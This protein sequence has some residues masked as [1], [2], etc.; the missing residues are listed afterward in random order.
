MPLRRY[1]AS[2]FAR[3]SNLLV[4]VCA[5]YECNR[6]CKYGDNDIRDGFDM[7]PMCPVVDGPLSVKCHDTWQQCSLPRR[8][9]D[10]R[11]DDSF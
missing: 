1:Y 3:Q 5:S 6:D 11:V 10:D 2:M 4:R 7:N 9:L 8:P